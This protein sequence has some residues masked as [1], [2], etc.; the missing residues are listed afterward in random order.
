MG[1]LDVVSG[2]VEGLDTSIES[3][4]EQSQLRELVLLACADESPDVRQSGLALMGDLARACP[5]HLMPTLQRCFEA[6]CATLQHEQLLQ[7]GA[8]RQPCFL[9]AGT[10][11]CWAIGELAL[12]A[13]AEDMARCVLPLLQCVATMLT[14]RVGAGGKGM[15]ENAGITLG[16]LALRCPEPMAPHL[17]S[18]IAPW[19]VALRRVRDG[20]EKEQAFTGLCTLVQ[21]NPMSALPAFVAMANAFASWR[22]L[23]NEA[24]HRQ[25]SE[26]MRGYQARVVLRPRVCSLLTESRARGQRTDAPLRCTRVNRRICQP[27]RGAKRGA[28]WSRRRR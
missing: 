20:A 19:C 1:A 13:P 24:L 27:R 9:L 4:A 14:L 17:Q 21:Q 16:R 25:M 18:F 22:T 7:P 2:M 28:A 3:L 15:L 26:I 12:R 8:G 10:N 23:D 6:C 11:A 5:S